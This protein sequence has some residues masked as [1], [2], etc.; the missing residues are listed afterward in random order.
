MRRPCTAMHPPQYLQFAVLFN[1]EKFFEAHEVLEDLW[2][3]VTGPERNFYQ[4]LI[5]IAAALVHVQ[6]GNPRGAVEMLAKAEKL[7]RPYPAAYRGVEI[8]SLLKETGASIQKNGNFPKIS[9][10]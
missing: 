2:R 10:K 7:S 5:Q 4:A 9:L 3:K 6:R 8:A 1:E